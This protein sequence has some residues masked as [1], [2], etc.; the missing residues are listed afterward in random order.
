MMA[1]GS[2]YEDRTAL[3]VRKASIERL[4][5]FIEH[6]S[7]LSYLEMN[8]VQFLLCDRTEKTEL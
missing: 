7:N 8:D 6:C 2:G 4:E 1:A 3:T 5:V